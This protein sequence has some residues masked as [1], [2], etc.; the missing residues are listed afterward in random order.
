MYRREALEKTAIERGL[1][2]EYFDELFVAYKEDVDLAYRL[3]LAGW[4]SVCYRRTI[5]YHV[6]G[7]RGENEPTAFG[8][9]GTIVNRR[10]KQSWQN[11]QSYKNHLMMLAAVFF[12]PVW[13]LTWWWTA[14]Y[15]KGKFLILLF[16]EP[17]TLT[18]WQA[19]FK[20]W[21]ALM[22]KRRQIRQQ[23][24]QRQRIAQWF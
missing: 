13:S 17:K 16:T 24:L 8:K 10:Q 9:A 12:F 2:R 23:G 1:G 11:K 22:M 7:L 20:N 18:A 3:Q 6:R 19:L 15:E 21:A 14:L 4:G 5:A